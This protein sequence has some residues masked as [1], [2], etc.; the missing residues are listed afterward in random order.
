MVVPFQY[1]HAKEP[2]SDTPQPTHL[3][4]NA[5]YFAVAVGNNLEMMLS[6]V[7]GQ[8]IDKKD[9]TRLSGCLLTMLFLLYMA[10][11][12]H[13]EVIYKFEVNR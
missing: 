4:N 8:R 5:L 9:Y 3:N 13:M 2:K 7:L 10:L 6:Q 1:R 11:W 12:V